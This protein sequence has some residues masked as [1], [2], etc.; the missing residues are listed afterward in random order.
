MFPR[1]PP[2][3]LWHILGYLQADKPSLCSASLISSLFRVP[4]QKLLFPSLALRSPASDF[5]MNGTQPYSPGGGL[6][7]LFEKS[8]WIAASIKCIRIDTKCH[9]GNGTW[10][11]ND[12]VLPAALSLIDLGSIEVFEIVKN[13]WTKLSLATRNVISTIL[14]SQS[15]VSLS[16]QGLPINILNMCG[17]AVKHLSLGHHVADIDPFH[18]DIWPP[19]PERETAWKLQTLVVEWQTNIE[20]LLEYFRNKNKNVDLSGLNRLLASEFVFDFWQLSSSTAL[21][22]LVLTDRQIVNCSPEQIARISTL[23]NLQELFIT[24]II[25]LSMGE[26]NFHLSPLRALI[27]HLNSVIPSIH[28]ACVHLHLFHRSA[29]FEDLHGDGAINWRSLDNLLSNSNRF[30]Q[31]RK[32]KIELCAYYEHLNLDPVIQNI[33]VCLPTLAGK[34]MLEF[35]VS[36]GKFSPFE[37]FF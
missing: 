31:F 2:E 36:T 11:E 3:L 33:S 19:K 4:C 10:I 35:K 9:G 22:A 18:P 7:Q 37:K 13:P 20:S 28:L 24:G 14:R 26:S 23:T 30:N 15:L 6:Q 21:E 1:L 17:P 27:T 32:I 34:G 8:P 16:I 5:K 29:R 12:S 25:G